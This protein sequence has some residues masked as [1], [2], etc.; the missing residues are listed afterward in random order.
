MRNPTIPCQICGE[1]VGK[2]AIIKH[3]RSC[4]ESN[5]S[6]YRVPTISLPP[7]DYCSF[8]VALLLAFLFA[9]ILIWLIDP[10]T[11][12]WNFFSYFANWFYSLLRALLTN[13]TETVYHQTVSEGIKQFARKLKNLHLDELYIRDEKQ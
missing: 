2:N 3:L 8:C 7:I 1:K 4:N 12:V 13:E 5:G 11:C 6:A 10:L 9:I